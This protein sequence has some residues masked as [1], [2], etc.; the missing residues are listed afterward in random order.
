MGR[1]SPGNMP[2]LMNDEES[3]DSK[4]SCNECRR[5]RT[6]C[7]REVPV[8]RL[9]S[10]YKRHCLYEKHSKTPLT[11]RHLTE[12]E[13]ELNLSKQLLKEYM[14]EVNLSQMLQQL[15][16][17][18]DITE[19]PEFTNKI[20]KRI[21]LPPEGISNINEN[22]Q[23]QISDKTLS[24]NK[25]G[26]SS[27][28]TPFLTR[29]TKPSDCESCINS[30]FPLSEI[31][32]GNRGL[33]D[34]REIKN[35]ADYITD[36]GENYQVPQLLPSILNLGPS[37]KTSFDSAYL[38][39][40]SHDAVVDLSP[41]SN[42]SS[43][44]WD[45]RK[46][47]DYKRR[48][49]II[50][51]MATTDSNGYL[52][53]PSSA[54]LINLVGGGFF[55]QDKLNKNINQNNVSSSPHPLNNTNTTRKIARQKLEYYVNQYF[56]TYHVS[57]PILH[58]PIFMAQFNE[59]IPTPRNGWESLLN[60]V[61][62]IGSFMC[63]VS[64][65]DD[66]DLI[67]FEIA[68]SK[69]SIEIME[70]GNLTL[71][72]T[73][74]LMS[75]YL[76]KR[77]RPNSGYSYLGLAVRMALALG[78]H[79]NI[80]NSEESL[81]DQE[82]RR[83]IWWC[84]YIFDCGQTITYGRPLG[85]PCAGFDTRLPMN[86]IDSNLT[87]LTKEIPDEELEPTIY[88][89]LR[90]QSLFHLLTNGIYERIIS[91]PFPTAYLLLEWDKKYLERWRYLT[92]SYFKEDANIPTKFKLAHCVL[93]WRYRNLRI[94]MYRTFLLKRVVLNSR[95]YNETSG[96]EFELKA[97]EICL[98]ECSVTIHSMNRF[99]TEKKNIIEWT[100]GTPCIL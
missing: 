27:N 56:E 86:I 48:S 80:E 40:G 20:H 7:T 89:S 73:I 18:S 1:R 3:G 32:M 68:K 98:Q 36:Q 62:A 67:L 69:L 8:C 59:V 75:N 50:D 74:I 23:Q 79:K 37:T 87:A 17:G 11:R 6:R 64:P 19:I 39:R 72:K 97:G 28:E 4:F 35:D 55:L 45:E 70:T 90:L 46:K 42:T 12:V 15:R 31:S 54:A 71:V 21:K 13:E 49:S 2:P 9:C 58:R 83:R 41:S 61:A 26:S 5:R 30:P 81:L 78:M 29:L 99:W 24:E 53:S 47:S 16:N 96:N 92:P 66:D 22:S 38:N 63:A 76:Q 60:I 88:T 33:N 10:K 57:Y 94:I 91:D 44:N 14:P 43:Y 25:S 51:G 77:D 95:S 34:Q 65:D 85:I 52:G 100:R 82:I 84:L 93:W